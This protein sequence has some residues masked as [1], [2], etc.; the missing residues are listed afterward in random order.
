VAYVMVVEDEKELAS[1][2]EDYLLH[3]GFEV[4]V[5]GN[6]QH[7]FDVICH[8]PPD[9]IVLDL[10]LPGLDGITMCHAIRQFSQVPIIMVTARTEE[11][12]RLVGL[13]VGADDYICKPFSPRE[14]VARVQAVLRRNPLMEVYPESKVHT[15]ES[16]VFKVNEFR[17]QIICQNKSLTL[18]PYEYKLLKIFIKNPGRLYTRSQLLDYISPNGMEVVDRV[19]DSHIKNIRRKLSDAAPRTDQHEWIQSVYGVG[20]RFEWPE[21]E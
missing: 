6:G 14:L 13:K 18:T 4:G 8:T 7:A 10:M 12:D 16:H 21:T 19:I 5:Y 3:A 1:L 20:Y 11:I 2:M 15:L 9:L 17:Q